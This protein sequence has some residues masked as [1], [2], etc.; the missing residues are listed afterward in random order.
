MGT[1][2]A[3][4]QQER[5]AAATSPKSRDRSIRSGTLSGMMPSGS[6][7]APKA[8]AEMIARARWRT[9]GPFDGIGDEVIEVIYEDSV[10]G[11]KTSRT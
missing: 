1:S 4:A 3:P 8:Q 10:T 6:L 2:A 9:S 11:L 7:S 5:K